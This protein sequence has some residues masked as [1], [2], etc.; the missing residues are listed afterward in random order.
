V[1]APLLHTVDPRLDQNTVSYWWVNQGQ[2][3]S[4]EVAGGYLWAPKLDKSGRH[5]I[6]YDSMLSLQLGDCVFSYFRGA[7]R[8]VG[9]VMGKARSCP[10][11]NFGFANQ[12]W[13]E[14]GW[15]VDVE[16]Q[17]LE[18]AF[19]PKEM[20]DEYQQLGPETHGP[21]NSQGRVN[22]EYLYAVSQS[23]GELYKHAVSIDLVKLETVGRAERSDEVAN[24]LENE[25]E[26]DI[27]ARTDI[28]PTEIRALTLARRGQ[29]YFRKQV[30]RVEPGCRLTGITDNR[31]LRASHIKP[32]SQS[33]DIERLDGANGLLLSPHVDHLFDQGYLSFHKSGRILKSDTLTADV[34]ARWKLNLE[35]NVGSFTK[36]QD[37]FLDFHRD[38]VF[39]P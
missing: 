25:V 37:Q 13:D 8:A 27:R 16:F 21:I 18:S 29:G 35:R 7:I 34:I 19:D 9:V 12:F 22:M 4:H 15:L 39:K 5:R 11:P 1:D 36:R 24:D 2:T 3:H 23:L 14:D 28:G 20:L 38:V 10:R 32:W 30:A 31:H 26:T 6:A 17:V 33:D